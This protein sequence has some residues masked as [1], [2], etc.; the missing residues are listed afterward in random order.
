MVTVPVARSL[1]RDATAQGSPHSGHGVGGSVSVEAARN[2]DLR[3]S[4]V[5]DS[6]PGVVGMPENSVREPVAAST[7]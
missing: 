4:G 6:T 3:G 1:V 2:L 5:N 7:R